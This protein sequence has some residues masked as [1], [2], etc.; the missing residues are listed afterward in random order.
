MSAQAL[1]RW[2]REQLAA[3]SI[4]TMLDA[5]IVEQ[6]AINAARFCSAYVDWQAQEPSIEPSITGQSPFTLRDWGLITPLFM[7]YIAREEA[8]LLEAS[9][10]MGV[11]VFGRSVSEIES[12]IRT[13]EDDMS[14]R[15]FMEGCFSL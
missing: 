1:I 13:L 8:K 6:T 12:E 2:A 3:R 14:R 15:I 5:P 7:A 9:R 10:I 4:P 11:D